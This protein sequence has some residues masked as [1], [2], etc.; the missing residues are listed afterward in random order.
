MGWR[1]WSRI[2]LINIRGIIAYKA[3]VVMCPL[4]SRQGA[5]QIQTDNPVR[6]LSY[7]I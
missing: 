3:I 4:S 1:L 2:P 5:H 6:F 7:K